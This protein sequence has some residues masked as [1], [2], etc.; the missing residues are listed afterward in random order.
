MLYSRF[1]SRCLVRLRNMQVVSRV[2]V[3]PNGGGGRRLADGPDA[4]RRHVAGAGGVAGQPGAGDEGEEGV[5]KACARSRHRF[6]AAAPRSTKNLQ[7][8]RDVVDDYPF[9][10]MDTEFPGVV[11]RPVGS[12][13]NSGEYH[14]QTLRQASGLPRGGSVF[15]ETP[16]LLTSTARCCRL[17]VDM[18]KLIQL[19]LTFT[20]AEGNLPRINGE[21]CVWQFNFK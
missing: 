10:A 9:L 21:L 1:R 15:C 7:L 18:L 13:K 20:D 12:F 17:N 19:G 8:I 3:G 6:T 2:E 5:A 11:A 4:R 16:V 14:Y